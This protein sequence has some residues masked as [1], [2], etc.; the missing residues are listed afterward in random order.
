V[1]GAE[2]NG[3]FEI[4]TTHGSSFEPVC[5]NFKSPESAGY[6][7]PLTKTKIK[8]LKRDTRSL[9]NRRSCDHACDA[10]AQLSQ[11]TFLARHQSQSFWGFTRS[12]SKLDRDPDRS[13]RP[14]YS[15][16]R[17]IT[18]QSRTLSLYTAHTPRS[19][20]IPHPRQEMR[21]WKQTH[22]TSTLYP[23]SPFQSPVKRIRL[24]ASSSDVPSNPDPEARLGSHSDFRAELGGH[25]TA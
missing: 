17:V 18:S 8:R 14:R 16:H 20:P 3:T 2:D 11:G 5:R 19:K 24:T 1:F 7:F 10:S 23:S 4:Y 6:M 13:K 21:H 12:P 25:I 9:F 15:T 22:Q